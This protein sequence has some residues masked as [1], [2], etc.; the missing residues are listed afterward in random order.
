[1]STQV[2]LNFASAGVLRF[3][4][5]PEDGAA[6]IAVIT[7]AFD[8]I[9]NVLAKMGL[10]E[11]EEWDGE[12]PFPIPLAPQMQA[13]GHGGGTA[14]NFQGYRRLA[15][16]A[17][18][19][20]DS[21]TFSSANLSLG[22]FRPGT[23]TFSIYD[24]IYGYEDEEGEG[25]W[26]ELPDYPSVAE[27]FKPKSLGQPARIFDYDIVYINC[28]AIEP[29]DLEDEHG[30][31]D[32]IDTLRAYVSNGGVLYVTDLSS[33]YIT[34][35][36]SE[37]VYFF[38]E[39]DEIEELTGKVEDTDLHNYLRNSQCME[40]SACASANGNV[41]LY[42]F[43]DGWH[44]LAPEPDMQ[45]PQVEKLV[46]GNVSSYLPF[47]TGNDPNGLT[48]AFSHGQGKVIFSSYHVSGAIVPLPFTAQER[49]LERLFWVTT[50]G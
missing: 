45:G 16:P 49:I 39:G 30:I 5:S 4:A 14:I 21:S 7:G 26:P 29:F 25:D 17:Q 32:W 11:W 50:G 35:A 37:Y 38:S 27:L 33:P 6:R 15:E 41:Q 46:T 43:G 31:D 22:S 3:P 42:D 48:L 34:G 1:M 20:G 23:E 12:L 24:G 44:L 2:V 18:V 36:F 19:T 28:G 40:G 8:N 47:P 10:A 9:E 13:L